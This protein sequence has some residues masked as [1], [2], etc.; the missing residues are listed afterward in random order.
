M[1]PRRD[2]D[3]ELEDA[4]R[5]HHDRPDTSIGYHDPLDHSASGATTHSQIYLPRHLSS[6]VPDGMSHEDVDAELD[7]LDSIATSMDSRWH[8][9]TRR[10]SAAAAGQSA[11]VHHDGGI[12]VGSSSLIAAIPVIGCI[13]L[14]I[15]GAYIIRVGSRLGV[16]KEQARKMSAVVAVAALTSLLLPIVAG[17]W[18]ALYKPHRRTVNTILRHFGRRPRVQSTIS[19]SK[20]ANGPTTEDIKYTIDYDN[21][22][23]LLHVPT[24]V[25][26]FGRPAPA[27]SWTRTLRRPSALSVGRGSA[28]IGMSSVGRRQSAGESTSMSISPAGCDAAGRDGFGFGM[29]VTAAAAG[30]EKQLQLASTAGSSAGGAAEQPSKDLALEAPADRRVSFEDLEARLEMAHLAAQHM[31]HAADEADGDDA[32]RNPFNAPRARLG[33]AGATSVTKLQDQQ[34]RPSVSTVSTAASTAQQ[35]MKT[36]EAAYGGSQVYMPPYYSTVTVGD[37]VADGGAGTS[38][39][40][41]SQLWSDVNLDT[42]ESQ[43]DLPT[44]TA[45]SLAARTGQHAQNSGQASRADSL[46]PVRMHV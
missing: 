30:M 26:A 31:Q 15:L 7:L 28:S 11:A 22:A 24:P 5:P 20:A 2:T 38:A 13:Y 29:A 8:L 3:A 12:Q 23:D 41:S 37:A 4:Y 43:Q 21:Y 40:R 36:A 1:Q 35:R 44:H 25:P 16:P 39:S 34:R 19:G 9:C 32:G 27:V 18:D 45:A 17:V 14:A 6:R 10:T 33:S 42:S 46:S